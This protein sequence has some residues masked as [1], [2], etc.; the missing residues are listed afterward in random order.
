[1]M[2]IAVGLA[3]GLAMGRVV[4]PG[5]AMA[6]IANITAQEGLFRFGIFGHL[7][8]IILDI[9]AAWAFYVYLLPLDKPLSLLAA[10]LRVIYAGFYGVALLNYFQLAQMLGQG[11]YAATLG[12]GALQTQVTLM[13]N[14]FH[15]VWDMGYVF[16]GLHLALLG[17]VLF[18]SGAIPKWVGAIV[19]M[20][21]ISYLVDYVSKILLVGF[22]PN[23]SLIFGWGELI[24]M[25]WL[26]LRGGKRK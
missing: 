10:W 24:F 13:L 17:W 11:G 22:A 9:V 16:F 15:D 25:F 20:G 3:E 26:F 2:V 12:S 8:V 1:L 5:D 6:T 18:K 21:G 23:V 19:L 4:V 14:A 7:M